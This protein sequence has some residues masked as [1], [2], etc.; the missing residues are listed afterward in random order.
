MLLGQTLAARQGA[1]SVAYTPWYP[2]QGDSATSSFEVI[3]ISD[4]TK[5]EFDV[6]T[7]NSEDADSSATGIGSTTSIIDSGSHDA[8]S[9]RDGFKE[10]FRYKVTLTAD[11]GAG[12]GID[13]YCHFRILNPSWKTTGVQGL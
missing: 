8:A 12:S 1:N 5:I 10:L 11:T 13:L 9:L 7:K 4:D 3:A 2:R 6:E